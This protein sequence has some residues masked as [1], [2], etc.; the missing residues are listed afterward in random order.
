[1]ATVQFL[2]DVAKLMERDVR[3]IKAWKKELG[4]PYPFKGPYDPAVIWDWADLTGKFTPP[5]KRPPRPGGEVAA[6][7]AG[8]KAAGPSEDQLAKYAKGLSLKQREM[9]VQKTSAQVDLLRQK[10]REGS[11]SLLPADYIHELVLGFGGRMR[12][13]QVRLRQMGAVPIAPATVADMM[14]RELVQYEADAM[15]NLDREEQT[16][17][18]DSPPG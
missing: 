1:M 14:E 15:R 3:S 11:K 10:H 7:A 4:F 13:L 17:P 12:Q 2:T 18:A 5:Y 16:T 9:T 6:A 8:G